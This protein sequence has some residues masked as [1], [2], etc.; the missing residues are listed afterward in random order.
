MKKYEKPSC[1]LEFM[2]GTDII[3]N[4]VSL[5]ISSD[6]D[7]GYVSWDDIFTS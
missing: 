6:N 7:C 3:S 2:L 4:S 1:K 5:N